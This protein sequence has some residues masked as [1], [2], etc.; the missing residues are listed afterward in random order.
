MQAGI[1]S[2]AFIRGRSAVSE[3]PDTPVPG[4]SKRAAPSSDQTAALDSRPRKAK[5]NRCQPPYTG[6]LFVKSG[7]GPYIVIDC[8]DDDDGEDIDIQ[9]FKVTRAIKSDMEDTYIGKGEFGYC[10]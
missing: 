10:S 8:D 9:V 2:S 6:T 1:D 3:P 7:D 4:S 5:P